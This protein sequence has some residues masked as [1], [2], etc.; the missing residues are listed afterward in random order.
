MADIFY[1]LIHPLP[2]AIMSV[3]MAI[4]LLY[5][6]F[7]FFSGA[8]LEDLDVGF[9]FD[10][11]IDVDIDIDTDIDVD[12]DGGITHLG[13]DVSAEGGSPG[14]FFQF[15]H[16]FNLG[17]IPFMF[18]FTVLNFFIWA[19]SLVTTKLIDITAWG[20][21]S[22][23]ILIPL[24]ILGLI[25]TKIVTNPLVKFFKE[26]GYKGEKEIDFFGRGGKMLSTISHKKMGTAEF[27]IDK[28]PIKLTVISHDGNELRYGEE[29]IIANESDDRKIFYVIKK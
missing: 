5:W 12:T 18:L 11:D 14:V 10:T 16:F 13:D 21:W 4:L 24:G 23:L 17:R 7:A 27:I 2:N 29:V 20:V 15:L 22:V 9:D 8:G 3:V 26:I 6:L 25:L 28:N 19:G 1:N